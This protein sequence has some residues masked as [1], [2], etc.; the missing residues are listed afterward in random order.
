VVGFIGAP[1]F[2]AD[3]VSIINQIIARDAFEVC[4]ALF[5]AVQIARC[6]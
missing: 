2:Q 1:T 5:A 6:F 4:Q 3:S